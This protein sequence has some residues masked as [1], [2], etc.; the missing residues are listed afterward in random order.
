MNSPQEIPA[1]LLKELTNP[2]I[3]QW[4]C[5][6]AETGHPP[7]VV[8]SN[9][10][11]Y[12]EGFSSLASLE[13]TYH[14]L[15]WLSK[16]IHYRQN[17][18]ILFWMTSASESPLLFSTWKN[19]QLPIALI[20]R[21][22]RL[23]RINSAF[24]R[25][26]NKVSVDDHQVIF[27]IF[28]EPEKSQIRQVIDGLQP[29]NSAEITVRLQSP[30][31]AIKHIEME[32]LWSEDAV[33]LACIARDISKAED[34]RRLDTLL[35]ELSFILEDPND[36]RNNLQQFLQ[37]ICSETQFEIAECWLP[38]YF[39][40]KE[41]LFTG[42]YPDD[43]QYRKFR[44]F[45]STLE[46]LL[47]EEESNNDEFTKVSNVLLIDDFP[48]RNITLECGIDRGY[49]IPIRLGKRKIA[50]LFFFGKAEKVNELLGVR[51]LRLLSGRLGTYI[52][53]RRISYESEQIFEL[54]P[55]FLCVLNQSGKFYKVNKRL[56]ELLGQ[57]PDD[58]RGQSFFDC[59]DEE[60]VEVG[61]NAF[62]Q[63]QSEPVVH[64]EAVM[65]NAEGRRFWLEW[66]ASL[67]K[68]DG[69]VYAAGQDLTI[70][71][72]Y[73]EELRTQNEKFMLLRQA[74]QDAIYEWDIQNNTIDWGDSLE[75]V[76]G[77]PFNS[78]NTIE[79]W[80]Q[81]LH[82]SD[83]ERVMNN[84]HAAMLQK[85]RLWSDEYQFRH[86]GDG[87]KF[88]LDRGIFLY[89][90]QGNAIRQ[91]GLMQDITALKQSEE[92]LL[93]L[94]NALQERAR[95]LLGFNKELE[96]FAYIVSHDLQEPLRMISSFM[97][98][99][100]NSKEVTMTERSEQYINFAIDGADRMKR[101]IQDLL[102]YSRIG[103]SEEDFTESNVR[104]I[105]HDTLLVYQQA[106]REKR[107]QISVAPMP[108]IKC[109]RSLLQQVFDNLISNAIKYND[110]PLPTVSIEYEELREEHRFS[111]VDNGIGIDP[112]HFET[113]YIP[114]KR[115]HQRNEYSGTGIGLA[116]CKK[117]IEKHGGK[118]E[119][120][121]QTGQG[122]TFSFTLPKL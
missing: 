17:Q 43:Q 7:V 49:S 95:Q 70:R 93:Q 80:E 61:L 47:D 108:H 110:K 36:F 30:G 86:A 45:S 51:L 101:L 122:S 82:P 60:Y 74:A 104:E 21:D 91:I 59:I 87:Y 11:N 117:I 18:W 3:K 20:Q 112:K 81:F 24:S 89:D 6:F 56:A 32:F 52:E 14:N 42:F 111:I 33:Q 46:D 13:T 63:L 107:V 44:D 109:I 40:K 67:G 9:T 68:Q 1:A 79:A 65:R 31:T 12:P 114:F 53:S 116:I 113:I 66:S 90:S 85:E 19:S 119:V 121:S 103:T 34:D 97:K 57:S 118:I 8:A 28:S 41:K 106:I 37:R 29:G 23:L 4:V 72:L 73:D 99:L 102:N 38:D 77:H 10:S 50:R 120:K 96:Q 69:I 98:L 105:I 62:Q 58:L 64:F 2:S 15:G 83:R 5:A 92:S 26:L 78:G 115:L 100:L 54:V 39:K 76:F 71:V 88:V 25:L 16:S 35:D 27:D 55:D 75:R 48:R 94:N 22:G 84:L